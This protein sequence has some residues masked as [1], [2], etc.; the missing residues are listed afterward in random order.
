[1]KG[2]L[3]WMVISIIGGVIVTMGVIVFFSFFGSAILD[4]LIGGQAVKAWV[5]M[6]AGIQKAYTTGGSVLPSWSLDW[7]DCRFAEADYFGSCPCTFAKQAN[8]E[9]PPHYFGKTT[10]KQMD[11]ILFLNKTTYNELRRIKM[12]SQSLNILG[13]CGCDSQN[14]NCMCVANIKSNSFDTVSNFRVTGTGLY[15]E[16]S[17][18]YA[19]KSCAWGTSS[20]IT[21][22]SK[23][24]STIGN[25]KMLQ[26]QKIQLPVKVKTNK[27]KNL[28]AIQHFNGIIYLIREKSTSGEYFIHLRF[29][30]TP[31][32]SYNHKQ[33]NFPLGGCAFIDNKV[34][35]R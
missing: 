33:K 19:S 11:A 23:F 22:A 27:Y 10:I 30:P 9:S 28:F 12:D 14:C 1:M 21:N 6:G 31:V 13:R 16:D 35:F 18:G 4:S 8:C 29:T 32:G 26:C 3:S 25:I 20:F 7:L 17:T 34:Y 15:V 2:K 5:Q 24:I